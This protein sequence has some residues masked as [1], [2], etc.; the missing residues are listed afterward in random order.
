MNLLKDFIEGIDPKWLEEHIIDLY[1][2]ERKQS[3]PAYAEAA[4][5]T[6]DLLVQ[7]GFEAELIPFPADGKTIYQDK[8]CPIGWEVS[9]MWLEVLSNVPGLDNPVVSDYKR[10]PISC[11]KHSVSTPPEGIVTRLIT[12]N[13][14]KAGE[15]VKG[16]FVLLNQS[17]RPSKAAIRMILDLGAIGWVSD[18]QEEGLNVDIDSYYWCN[19]ATENGTWSVIA[20]DRDFISYQVTPRMAFALRSACEKGSVFVRAFS[21]GRRYET[22]QYAVTGL[23]PGEDSREVWMVSHLY[24]PLIDDNSNGIIGSIALMKVLRKLVEEGKIKLKYSVRF[25]GASEMY[26][27]SAV[28]EYYG[29]DLSK[30]CIGGINTDGT[31]GAIDKSIY[32]KVIVTEAPDLP[33]FVGNLFMQIV[34][35]HT[36]EAVPQMN[37][38][39]HDHRYADDCFLSDPTVGIPTVWFRHGEGYH[40]HASQDES[41]IAIEVA[42][43]HLAMHGEWVRLM[44]AVSEDEVKE[45]LPRAVELARI[46]LQAAAKQPV[47]K[48]TDTAA[49]L[50]FIQNREQEKIRGLSLYG[51]LPEIEE[52][53]EQI[54]LPVAENPEAELPDVWFEYAKQ[55]VFARTH[56]GFPHDLMRLPVERRIYLPEGVTYGKYADVLSRMDGKKTFREI[57]TEIEWDMGEILDDATVKRFLRPT[58]LLANAGYLSMKNDHLLTAKALTD[59]LRKLGVKEGDTL[60]VHSS[61][62]GLGYFENGTYSVMEAIEEAVG[63]DGTYLAPA[64]ARPYLSFDGSPNKSNTYRPYDTRPD[65]ELRDKTIGTGALP[66]AMLKRAD[67]FR[68]GHVSHEWVGIGAKAEYCVSG[69]GLLDAPTGEESPLKKALE[70]DGSVVLMG[71]GLGPNTFIHYIE[72]VLDVPY[73]TPALLSYIDKNGKTRTGHIAKHLGG[74]RSFYAGADSYFYKEAVKRGLQIQEEDF[75]LG[76]IYRIRIRDLYEIGMQ[77]YGEDPYALLCHKERC[78]FC[79]KHLP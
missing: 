67:A 60:L 34:A 13:Q 11:A 1:R 69:H 66:K 12:E 32:R 23:L 57:I 26:G 74:C 49:R 64:F 55:F 56:R 28:A 2:I 70:L 24:E 43:E 73:L 50:R 10:E 27:M 71:C 58:V 20:Q 31:I 18:Y 63:E 8:C 37:L 72:T 38:Q 75:G 3:F 42:R 29:G 33:G 46:S 22:T 15:D 61:L 16:A 4:K 78:S 79:K 25:V 65:G 77:I 52:A 45:I 7:E 51:A 19:A 36:K 6:Y 39:F 76:K 54:D 40:H 44:A 41:A 68:S 53:C 14:M 59:T 5:Y 21:D 9:D 30:R 17:T 47:R 62:S 48:G 35:D